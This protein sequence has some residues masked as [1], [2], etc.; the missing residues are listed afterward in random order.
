MMS[1]TV[2]TG[3]YTETGGESFEMD[4]PKERQRATKYFNRK[5][6]IKYARW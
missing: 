2:K 3:I 1:D 6:Q 5:Q 4:D